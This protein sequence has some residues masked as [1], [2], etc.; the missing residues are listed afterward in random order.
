MKKCL[1][2]IAV[3]CSLSATAQTDEAA[4]RNILTTQTGAW[5]RGDLKGFMQTYWHSDS[6]LFIGKNGVQYGW[7]SALNNYQKSYPDTAAMGR[8][9]FDILVAKPLSPQYYYVVG[10]WMLQRSMGNLS[11]H[12]DILLRKINGQWYIVADHSS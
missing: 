5:N 4:I 11:G 6:L 7:Q 3:F 10:K 1:F 8:L 2:V 12:F 9:S